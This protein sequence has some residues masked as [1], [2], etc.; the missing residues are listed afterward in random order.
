MRLT[1]KE[2]GELG[3]ALIMKDGESTE[4]IHFDNMR[5]MRYCEVFLMCGDVGAN[6]YNK[7]GLNNEVNPKDTCPDSIMANFSTEAVME[8]YDVQGVFLNGPRN[9]ILDSMNIPTGTK[10]RDFNGLKARL[11]G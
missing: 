3:C 6:V 11:D 2:E 10:V 4:V 8:Q 7:I 5:D 9:F 1:G